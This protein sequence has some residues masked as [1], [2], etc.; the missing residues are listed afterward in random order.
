[1]TM[2]IDFF[3]AQLKTAK[4]RIDQLSRPVRDYKI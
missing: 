2:N 1:M 3:F 4:V